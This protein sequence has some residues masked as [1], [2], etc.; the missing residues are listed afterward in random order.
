MATAAQSAASASRGPV[1]DPLG[2]LMLAFDGLE[3]PP[4][5][6]ARLASA[7]AAGITLFR[8]LNV[9]TAEQV[10]ALT[11]SIQAA[12]AAGSH[13]ADGPLLIAADQEGGQL[14]ALGDVCTPFAG[15]MAI[16]A[17]GDAGLAERV[18]QATGVELLA[19]GVN[20]AYVPSCDLATNPRNPGIGIRSFG[21]DPSAVAGLA[22]AF[23]RGLRSAGVAATVKHFPGLGDAASDS[24][25]GLPVLDHDGARLRATELP[26]F[27]AAIEA[28][29]ELVMSAHVGLPQLTG[30][31]TLPATMS[32]AVL[33]DLLRVELGFDGLV[34]SDALDM[35]AMPQGEGQARAVV[36]AMAAGVDLLLCSADEDARQRIEAA[37]TAAAADGRLVPATVAASAERLAR[38]RRRL[39]GQPAPAPEVVGSAEHRALARELAER[40]MTLVRNDAGL[41][42][43]RLEPDTRIAAI[44]PRPA[45]LTPADTSSQV[46][47]ALTA[48][49]RRRHAAVT[50]LVVPLRPDGNDID[51][52]RAAAASH[53]LI[54]VGTIAAPL[55]PEQA[56][57]I[58]ALLATGLPVVT[59]ALR[60]P[61]DLAA[62]PAARTHACSYG[63]LPDSLNALADA[64]FGVIEFRGRLPA[65][66]E[67][68]A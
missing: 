30:D 31:A 22:A 49:L 21:S 26:P 44:M 59:A 64:L 50:D 24:H 68:L 15:N 3:L 19:L 57:L 25:L 11:A 55:H 48:A 41:L 27:R 39:A 42:P 36:D 29:A 13:A 34:I 54:V 18:G 9:A 62:Y 60:T 37:L 61:F 20:V 23:T 51:G 16:G 67:G 4:T 45:D 52:A 40:S 63:I 1:T 58:E 7:P 65:P 10:R 28:G 8:Y 32:R 38:L 14:L 5:M 17:A 66:I 2:L 6:A 35:A 12:A 53:D 43:L 56:R 47:P 33:H 46:P